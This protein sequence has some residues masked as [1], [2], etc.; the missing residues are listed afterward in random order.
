MV[1]L[2]LVYHS[3]LEKNRV[4]EPVFIG[5]LRRRRTL[6]LFIAPT[7]GVLL[8]IVI[9]PLFFSLALSFFDWNVIE[10]EPWSWVGLGNYSTILFQDPYF[11]T[12]LTVTVLYLLG[13]VPLQLVLGLIV[14]LIL[15][16]IGQ[17]IIN[18]LRTVLVIPAMMT[19]LIVGIIW[20]LMYNPDMGM[21]NYF[22]SLLRLHPII[23]TGMPATALPSV[24]IADIWEWT[25]F[26]A[27]ILLAGLQAIPVEPLEGARVDGASGW[28]TLRFVV[29]PLLSPVILVAI[30][31]RLMDSFKTF[32]L[33][34]VLTQGGPGMSTEILNYYTYRNGFKFFHMGYASALSWLLVIILNVI[35][36]ILGR[37]LRSRGLYAAGR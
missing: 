26:I 2:I 18:S 33:I 7:V 27:L 30:L 19:P 31:V 22:L 1:P 12:S 4:G 20:R 5:F 9:F 13:T 35:S 17:K 15:N 11:R 32:D 36:M 29:L 21:L 16:R 37:T 34:F 8:A 10:A 24:M 25:P 23:W 3:D 14:A 6:L 28:Q